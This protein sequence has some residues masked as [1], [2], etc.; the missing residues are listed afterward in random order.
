MI[1]FLEWEKYIYFLL[2]TSMYVCYI[3][4]V[5]YHNIICFSWVKTH[6]NLEISRYRLKVVTLLP[7]YKFVR[8]LIVFVLYVSEDRQSSMAISTRLLMPS[9]NILCLIENLS[10]LYSVGTKLQY[11]SGLQINTICLLG[12]KIIQTIT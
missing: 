6:I 2:K 10:C 1:S 5:F 8:V 9:K 3:Y 4:C 12:L 7:H 11:S